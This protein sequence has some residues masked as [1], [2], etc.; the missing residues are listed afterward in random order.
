MASR[1]GQ[2]RNFAGRTVVLVLCSASVFG[3]AGYMVRSADR[4]VHA[5]IHS[6]ELETLKYT[7][8]IDAGPADAN[9]SVPRVGY[10]AVPQTRIFEEDLSAL[11]PARFERQHG[12]LGPPAPLA[13]DEP[14][15][16]F[17]RG[18][19][20]AAERFRREL[21]LGPPAPLE[22]EPL[23]FALFDCVRYGVAHSRDYRS[24]MEDVYL[25]ALNVTLERHLFRPRPFAE[26]GAQFSRSGAE[27]D[28]DA[29]FGVTS[30]AGVRQQ[31]PF[32]GEIVASAL[33]DFVDALDGNIQNG[34]SA[35]L[36]L[37]A[38]VPLLR[39]AG[40]VN[41][42]PL[43]ASERE[44][45]YEIRSFES[46]RRTFAVDVASRYFSL[47]A[48]RQSI[49]NRYLRYL[50]SIQLLARTE[51]L[52]AADIVDRLEVQRAQQQ[53][54]VSEDSLNQAEQAYES[55]LDRF[56]LFLGMPIEQPLEIVPVALDVPQPDLENP[57]AVADLAL[58]YRLDLQSARDRIADA[59]RQVSIAKNALLPDLELSARGRVGSDAGSPAARISGDDAD[60]TAGI[61]LA[62]PLDRL[63][64]RNNLRRSLINL[65][66]AQRGVEEAE[67]VVKADV[68]DS[69]RRLRTALTSLRIQRQGIEIA[70][71]R[72]DFANSSL[73][74]GRSDNSRNAVEAQNALL[75]AQDAFE[76]AQADLQVAVL[77][78]LLDTGTLRVDPAA[79]SLGEAMSRESY[80]GD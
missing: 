12:P 69:V 44:L 70:R 10:R 9:A 21:R 48:A 41:L 58:R 14:R 31:L 54:L 60:I 16:P 8:Q 50:S 1:D 3:C 72:L 18:D 67:Q 64:E 33:V 35:E 71:Q 4:Q 66:R 56:K 46:Y 75:E 45:I 40:L 79:G 34:E 30:R 65:E 62:L 2:A 36:A 42:E 24:R 13:L 68:R 49:R 59:K 63:A 51:A 37:Q 78:F 27:A 53:V 11:E 55:A 23:S 17:M 6:R 76:Q 25:A 47:L 74:M 52:F 57:P 26:V 5:I 43:I 61:D 28:Y 7:P 39:G 73:L 38:S 22:G 80:Q 15:D 29:A 20:S 19:T 32:G 77:N